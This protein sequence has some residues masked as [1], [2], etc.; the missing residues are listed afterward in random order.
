MKFKKIISAALAAVML[1]SPIS[2]N[3]Y[4]A[5][6]VSSPVSSVGEEMTSGNYKYRVFDDNTTALTKYTGS[7]VNVVVPS[8]ID[9]HKVVSLFG[10]FD[11]CSDLVSVTIPDTVTS[12]GQRAFMD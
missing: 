3:A 6:D 12:V 4:L 9:G 1:L 10:T 8:E 2:A 5:S 7:S 11:S